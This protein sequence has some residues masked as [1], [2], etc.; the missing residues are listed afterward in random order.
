MFT[1]AV[2]SI[3][4]HFNLYLLLCPL[5]PWT[6]AYSKNSK[7]KFFFNKITK[8]STYEL[9]SSAV[10]PFQYVSQTLPK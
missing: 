9:H 5:E 8:E 2:N 6:M 3:K 1:M 4:H 7:K 10:A